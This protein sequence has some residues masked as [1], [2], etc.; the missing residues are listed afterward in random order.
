MK[1]IFNRIVLWVNY[2]YRHDILVLFQD[3]VDKVLIIDLKPLDFIISNVRDI[4]I[5]LSP[6]SVVG[7]DRLGKT[8]KL[9]LSNI[10][11]IISNSVVKPGVSNF[12]ISM[13]S[14]FL[15]ELS[16]VCTL[17]FCIRYYPFILI[18]TST[19]LIAAGD[20]NISSPVVAVVSII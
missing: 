2:V 17:R 10:W 3:P 8:D 9:V 12:W 15:L 14:K 16:A 20:Y 1:N 5:L 6:L 19:F 18:S 11:Q 7:H 4:C 13:Y